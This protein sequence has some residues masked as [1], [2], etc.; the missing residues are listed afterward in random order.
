MVRDWLVDPHWSLRPGSGA[1]AQ[2]G[3]DKKH[4]TDCLLMSAIEQGPG[5]MDYADGGVFEGEWK[6]DRIQ[7]GDDSSCCAQSIIR[8]RGVLNASGN[9]RID[10]V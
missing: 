8:V 5:R 3:G 4:G 7:T 6:R 9:T 1:R 2:E 10:D